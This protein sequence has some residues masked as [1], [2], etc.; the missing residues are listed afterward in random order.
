VGDCRKRRKVRIRTFLVSKIYLQSRRYVAELLRMRET[1]INPL[2]RPHAD[3]SS[4]TMID[5]DDT[6]TSHLE[7]LVESLEHFPF[8]SRPSAA[9]FEDYLAL[10]CDP[11]EPLDSR[12][13]RD[14]FVSLSLSLRSLRFPLRRNSNAVSTASLGRGSSVE[15]SPTEREAFAKADFIANGC[16]APHQ[17][18]DDLRLCLE[19]IE[20]I[21]E[22]HLKLIEALR[23]R[24]NGQYP[25]VRSL[26]DVF[27]DNVRLCIPLSNSPDHGL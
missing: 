21:L 19:A 17:L 11:R 6:N 1:F 16:V 15:L 7:T 3:S 23:K 12:T 10:E 4:S 25:L 18:P 2:L 20:N 8:A 14:S 22:D 24:Y 13:L 9:G 27:L 26:A 5:C